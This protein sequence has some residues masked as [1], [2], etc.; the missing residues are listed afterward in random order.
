MRT[1]V[2]FMAALGLL[3]SGALAPGAA[4][5]DDGKKAGGASE[6]WIYEVRVVRVEHQWIL[7]PQCPPHDELGWNQVRNRVYAVFAEVIGRDIGDHRDV[8]AFDAQAAPQQAAARN[9]QHG[10]L[11]VGL[12]QQHARA[13]FSVVGQIG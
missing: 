6:G 5:A 8:G 2:T 1:L 10:H 13:G 11:H 4:R 9:L 12:A 3:V 7:R